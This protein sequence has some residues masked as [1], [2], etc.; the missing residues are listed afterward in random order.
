MCALVKSQ[1]QGQKVK[2][3]GNW[4]V[5]FVAFVGM[6]EKGVCTASR[7]ACIVGG[8]PSLRNIVAALE[9]L[10]LKTWTLEAFALNAEHTVAQVRARLLDLL[11]LAMMGFIVMGCGRYALVGYAEDDE[12]FVI[13]CNR[14][15]NSESAHKYTR[16]S[17]LSTPLPSFV[18]NHCSAEYTLDSLPGRCKSKG[19]ESWFT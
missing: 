19:L 8:V 16:V 10:S 1:G 14:P 3:V 5:R 13:C 2:R 12:D 11:I 6:F 4:H 18:G 7:R 17:T 9:C 15:W